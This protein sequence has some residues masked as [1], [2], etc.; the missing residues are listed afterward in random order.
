M[1]NILR[2]TVNAL[3]KNSEYLENKQKKVD[4]FSAE[5][6]LFQYKIDL[7]KKAIEILTLLIY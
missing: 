3:L 2:I 1:N 5:F 4:H 6:D 7:H